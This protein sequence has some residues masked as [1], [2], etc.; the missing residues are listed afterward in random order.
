MKITGRVDK[1]FT[2]EAEA[3][4]AILKVVGVARID[5]RVARVDDGLD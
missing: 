4:Q 2:V 3:K 5:G 1:E